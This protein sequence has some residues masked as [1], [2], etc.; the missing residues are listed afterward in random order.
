[1]R[2]FFLFFAGLSTTAFAHDAPSG[3]QY[4]TACCSNLD[5]RQVA[6]TAISER[7]QGYIVNATGEVL[8][9][10][11]SRVRISPDGAYHWC[12]AAGKAYGKTICLFVPPRAY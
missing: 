6:G 7:P 2:L 4:P 9:Y 1:M 8:P 10:A 11:D 3:W 5:C 12:S